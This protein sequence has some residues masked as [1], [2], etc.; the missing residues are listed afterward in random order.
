MIALFTRLLITS[1][2]DP[3]QLQ[4]DLHKIC[5]WT[6]KWQ[7][8]INV[9]K[10]TVLRC[11]HSLNPIQYTYTLSIA[12]CSLSL[13]KSYTYLTVG[14]TFDNTMSWSSHIQA[15]SNR[16]T[17]VLNFIKRNLYNCPLDTAYLTLVRPIMEYVASVW[18][19]Y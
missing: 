2:Q 18:D 13:K 10:C 17:K 12:N 4:E 6:Q 14:V 5:E 16:A 19:P 7:M 3:E 11:T 1:P 8:K 15:V 9:D